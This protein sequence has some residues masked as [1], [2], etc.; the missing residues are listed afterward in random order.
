MGR[1]ADFPHTLAG[2]FESFWTGMNNNYVFWGTDPTNW[3]DIYRRFQ[4]KFAELDVN[5]SADIVVAFRHFTEMTKDLIDGHFVITIAERFRGILADA[6]YRHFIF[7]H[8]AR[9]LQR[10]DA[11]SRIPLD[12]FIQRQLPGIYLYNYTAKNS[13]SDGLSMIHGFVSN[14]AGKRISYFYISAFA[15]ARNLGDTDVRDMII[16]WFDA[17][18][19]PN[20]DGVIIDL[21]GNG[22]GAVV[23]MDILWANLLM[24]REFK[25]GYRTQK[26][27]N[28][29]LDFG[30]RIPHTFRLFEDFPRNENPNIANIPI[31]VL[32]DAHSASASEMS[33][34]A[35]SHLPNVYFV[36]E[37][38]WGGQGNLIQEPTS[39]VLFNAGT[40]ANFFMD[41]VYT[42]FVIIDAPN[43]INYE[44]RGFSPNDAPRGFYIRH[45]AAFAANIAAGI[46]R[47]LE[48]AI[49]IITSR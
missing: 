5:D 33:T 13:L 32:A 35:L 19:D 36:G 43:G 8:Q 46:D 21:R 10:N 47:Q 11:R 27:G 20:L 45:N 15:I 6:G 16:K 38:T 42:P 17:I 39:I 7:P 18:S 41:L 24:G 14:T 28:G 3:D 29:R 37:T 22:G 9:Y 12:N 44:G 2:A 4:P 30:P 48:K 23:D 25:A 1:P 40:F 34:M 26:I 31:V 49:E